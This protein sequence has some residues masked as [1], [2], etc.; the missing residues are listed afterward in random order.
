MSHLTY[1]MFFKG[2]KDE[3][4]V[5]LDELL[6][7]NS[8]RVQNMYVQVSVTSH[9]N[10]H[11]NFQLSLHPSWCPTAG[12]YTSCINFI[13]PGSYHSCAWALLELV[14]VESNIMKNSGF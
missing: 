4:P 1:T 12:A 11:I 14:Q 3:E 6:N 10:T 2:L 9:V 8:F 5:P 13:E 7:D